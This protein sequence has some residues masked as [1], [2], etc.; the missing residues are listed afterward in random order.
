MFWFLTRVVCK[1]Q[2]ELIWVDS[3]VF[4]VVVDVSNALLSGSSATFD[5]IDPGVY[6]EGP[7]GGENW[8]V[9]STREIIWNADAAVAAGVVDVRIE[10]SRDGG[11]SWADIAPSVDASTGSYPWVVTDGGVALPQPQCV[12][13]ISD[14][15]DGNPSDSSAV[16][17]VFSGVWYVDLN[18]PAGGDGLTWATAFGHPQDAMDAAP[19][20]TAN[21]FP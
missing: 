12:V 13:R 21:R 7:L 15:A 16:F 17:V 9:N 14:A 2:F 1:I 18:A 11:G 4:V 10:I 5:I 3:Q 8:P 20:A 19:A 6:L